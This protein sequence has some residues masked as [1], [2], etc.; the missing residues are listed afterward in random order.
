MFGVL[1]V[2][3]HTIKGSKLSAMSLSFISVIINAI[4]IVIL[5][6]GFL[7]LLVEIL[8]G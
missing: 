6:A 8:P 5:L 2:V 1:A 3:N 7:E 4:I